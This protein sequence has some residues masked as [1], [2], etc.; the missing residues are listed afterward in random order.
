MSI[1]TT[2][3]GPLAGQWIAD[4]RH[5]RRFA[6]VQ[7]LTVR[8]ITTVRNLAVGVLTVYGAGAIASAVSDKTDAPALSFL[9]GVAVLVAGSVTLGLLARV[10]AA[11]VVLLAALVTAILWVTY[12][13]SGEAGSGEHALDWR[14]AAGRAI[15]ASTLAAV[16][17]LG[18]AIGHGIR[19]TS[20]SRHASSHAHGNTSSNRPGSASP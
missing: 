20:T 19:M 2:A 6:K 10:R 17:S 9:A 18:V 5:A 12:R 7:T 8:G 16:W 13:A 15:A 1:G 3:S 4:P 14:A 11:E